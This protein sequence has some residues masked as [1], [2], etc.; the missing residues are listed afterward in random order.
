[1]NP[2]RFSLTVPWRKVTT[3]NHFWEL[4]SMSILNGG[5]VVEQG[6]N[7]KVL[8]PLKQ[9]HALFEDKG[10]TLRLEKKVDYIQFFSAQKL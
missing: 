8:I 7:D 10:Y 1:M 6:S 4:D 9:V 2:Y 5:R 3:V